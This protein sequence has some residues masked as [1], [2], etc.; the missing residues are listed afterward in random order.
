MCGRYFFSENI[1]TSKYLKILER[2]Y[3]QEVLDLWQR[4]EICPGQIALVELDGDC[5][6][7]K[8]NYQLFD[9]TL[10]NTR[11]ESIRDK[12]FYR[13]DFRQHRCVIVASGFYEW[14]DRQRHYIST[15]QP[16]IY[17]AGI[18]QNT[19][20]LPQFSIITREATSTRA[21]HHRVPVVL[22]YLQAEDYLKNRLTVEQLNDIEPAFRIEKEY[23]NLSLF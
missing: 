3:E 6:L 16:A 7:M 19:D 11:L 1:D 23:E 8:W 14:K 15:D 17:L 10:I 18:Y 5:G 22:D 13:D 4:G 21:I 12:N 2:K 9:R 20:G